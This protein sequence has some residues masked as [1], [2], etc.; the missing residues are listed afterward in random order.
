MVEDF[1]DKVREHNKPDIADP[2][3]LPPEVKA[4]LRTQSFRP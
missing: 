4:K 3:A 1:K 2:S